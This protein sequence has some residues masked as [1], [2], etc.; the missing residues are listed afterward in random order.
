M[1]F[2]HL[3]SFFAF[4]LLQTPPSN[5]WPEFRGPNGDG[6]AHESA[7]PPLQFDEKQNLAWKANFEGK[8]WSSPVSFGNQVWLTTATETGTEYSVVCVD[9]QS[10]KKLQNITLFKQATPTDIRRFNTYAS[11]TPAIEAGR[12]Y[13]HY[14]SHGTACVDTTTGKIL[15]ERKD[16]PCDHFRGPASSPIIF[17][18]KLY[19]L[20][21]GHDRQFLTCLDKETGKTIWET[22]RDLPYKNSG[23]PEKDNDYKKAYATANIFKVGDHHEL[24][25]PAAMGTVAYDPKTGKEIWRVV[26]DGMNQASRPILAHEM[27]FVTAGH[28]STMFAIKTGGKGDITNSHVAY[29]KAKIA[30]TRPSPTVLGDDLYFVNDTGVFFCLEA[31]TG[32]EKWKESLGDKF[33]A[34]PVFANGHFYLCGESGTVYVIKKCDTFELIHK[35]K[36]SDGIKGSPIAVGNNLIVKTYSAIYCFKESK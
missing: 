24:V 4:I 17:D 10:G 15:W 13:A 34:S 30:P 11:P 9:L 1:I 12:L 7:K 20:F 26:T 23:D 25:A 3:T 31:K 21:D 35:T 5:S 22:K 14:G 8:S 18:G 36:L 32:K 27:I 2:L 19:L 6:I 29:K 28:T 16:I 33:S